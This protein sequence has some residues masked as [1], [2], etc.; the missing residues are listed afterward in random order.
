MLQQNEDVNNHHI[1]HDD[2]I[3]LVPSNTLV[4]VK[5][6][7]NFV[8]VLLNAPVVAE[9]L[10]N[11]VEAIEKVSSRENMI[12]ELGRINANHYLTTGEKPTIVVWFK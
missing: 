4:V 8:E 10:P 3:H 7:Q 11:Q 1:N 2:L 9:H 5:Q 12:N 6:P